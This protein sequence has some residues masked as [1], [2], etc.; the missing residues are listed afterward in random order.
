MKRRRGILFS[1]REGE[2]GGGGEVG[3]AVY[4][5][6]SSSSAPKGRRHG[7]EGSWG[8]VRDW[9]LISLTRPGCG[10]RG[11][12]YCYENQFIY[13]KFAVNGVTQP[14]YSLH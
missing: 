6:W 11:N 7:N 3:A 4:A 2:G 1:M 10:P 8:K 12:K 14:N 9:L 5:K 13:C